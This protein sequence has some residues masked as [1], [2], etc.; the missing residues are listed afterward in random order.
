MNIQHIITTSAQAFG[1][2]LRWPWPT[3][4]D[5]SP[6]GVESLVP[7]VIEQIQE[8]ENHAV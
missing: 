2:R 3:R 6:L 7:H 1:I 5:P 4:N 8:E